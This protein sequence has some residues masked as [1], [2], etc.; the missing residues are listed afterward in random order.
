[1]LTGRGGAG[2]RREGATLD[3]DKAFAGSIP[4]LYQRLLGP[5]LFEPYAADLAARLADMTE[6]RALE[7]AAG[8]GVLTR[9]LLA[10]LPEAVAVVATDLNQAMLDHAATLPAPRPVERRQADACALPFP[11]A[12]FDAVACQFGVMF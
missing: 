11:D 7:T 12:T 6:G 10:R 8:T 9:A 3:T 1:G 4:A 2:R 5:L